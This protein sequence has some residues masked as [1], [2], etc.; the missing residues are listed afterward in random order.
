[1]SQEQ[2]VWLSWLTWFTGNQA[3]VNCD[4]G[5]RRLLLVS[6]FVPGLGT[7]C[8]PG[9]ERGEEVGVREQVSGSH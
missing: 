5:L 4:H 8:G 9:G 7:V 6:A 2:A 1:M 3:S